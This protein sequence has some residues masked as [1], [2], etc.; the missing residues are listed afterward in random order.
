MHNEP[1]RCPIR[2]GVSLD[3]AGTY[4]AGTMHQNRQQ[5]GS[6]HDTD[7]EVEELRDLF[8]SC[9][10]L[11]EDELKPTLECR[12]RFEWSR[13]ELTYLENDPIVPSDFRDRTKV[14]VKG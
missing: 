7:C 14:L 10:S 5:Q 8:R 11:K 3:D 12:S 13:F 1:S 4:V 6:R 9:H 2:N